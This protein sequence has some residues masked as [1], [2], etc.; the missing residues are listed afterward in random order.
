LEFVD[1]VSQLL[2]LVLFECMICL[3]ETSMHDDAI[4]FIGLALL[5]LLSGDFK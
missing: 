2:R 1:V 4:I 5:Y 3:C